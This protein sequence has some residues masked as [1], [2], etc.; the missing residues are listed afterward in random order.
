MHMC[1]ILCLHPFFI[2]NI[3][4]NIH[5]EGQGWSADSPGTQPKILPCFLSL[6][7]NVSGET[8]KLLKEC[9]W[10]LLLW[11]KFKIKIK[12]QETVSSIGH[13]GNGIEIMVKA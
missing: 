3:G 8:S 12:N 4:T 11:E 2:P 13:R 5:L 7:E 1:H 6:V 9:S 10:G